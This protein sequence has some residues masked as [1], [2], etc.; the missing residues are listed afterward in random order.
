MHSKEV[1]KS[2]RNDYPYPPLASFLKVFGIH[3][4]GAG[5]GLRGQSVYSHP[6]SREIMHRK[7]V[8]GVADGDRTHDNR[9]HNPA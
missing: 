5:A 1:C 7:E 8:I 9:N 6:L 4:R 3:R 2:A